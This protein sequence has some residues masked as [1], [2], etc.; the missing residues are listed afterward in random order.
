M[1]SLGT[2]NAMGLMKG[3]LQRKRTCEYNQNTWEHLG[4]LKKT[5]V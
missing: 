4:Q 3:W 1:E 2:R 5:Q